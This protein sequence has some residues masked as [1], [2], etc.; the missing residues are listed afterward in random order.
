M[1]NA[2][3]LIFYV[4]LTYCTSQCSLLLVIHK[5]NNGQPMVMNSVRHKTGVATLMRKLDFKAAVNPC[6]AQQSRRS[7]AGDAEGVVMQ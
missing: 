2:L 1:I 3:Q 6:G 4:V 7:S 5:R